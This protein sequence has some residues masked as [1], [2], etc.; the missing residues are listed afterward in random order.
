MSCSKP[1]LR[2]FPPALK[3]FVRAPGGRALV[4]ADYS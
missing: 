1:N 2:Q 4:V 3:S